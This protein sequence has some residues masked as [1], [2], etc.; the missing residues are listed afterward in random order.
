M[1]KINPTY[2][3]SLHDA[4]AKRPDTVD[5]STDRKGWKAST[6]SSIDRITLS[7]AGLNAAARFSNFVQRPT[8]TYTLAL[9]APLNIYQTTDSTPIEP[10]Q[11]TPASRK[12]V[13]TTYAEQQKSGINEF[14]F[15]GS[16]IDILA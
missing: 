16:Q 15:P 4:L 13:R 5:R 3:Y 1:T 9:P 6:A 8:D 2:N 14:V 11:E 10:A 7:S 12:L